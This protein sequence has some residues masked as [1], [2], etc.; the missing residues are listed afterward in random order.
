[1]EQRVRETTRRTVEVMPELSV[2]MSDLVDKAVTGM[3]RTEDVVVS[4]DGRRLAVATINND[5]IVILDF[6]VEFRPDDPTPR[7]VALTSAATIGCDS[8][9][10]PHGVAW[11]DDDTLLVGNRQ[12]EVL[13]LDISGVGALVDGQQHFAAEARVLLGGERRI[14]IDSPGSVVVRATDEELADIVVCNNYT[15]QV[16]RHVV[17]RVHDYACLDEDIIVEAGLNV[18]DGAA[19]SRA[20]DWL[21][22]SNHYTHEVFL[23]RYDLPFGFAREPDGVLQGVNYPHG[24]RFTADGRYMLVADAG[25]PYV[26]VY[27]AFHGDW[28]GQRTPLRSARVMDDETFHAGR[29]NPQE[30]GPKGLEIIDAAGVVVLTSEAQS[31]AFFDLADLTG[32]H[33]DDRAPAHNVATSA[34]AARRLSARNAEARADVQR[35][36]MHCDWQAAVVQERED[37]IADLDAQRYQLDE[38]R[39]QLGEQLAASQAEVERLS[40]LVGEATRRSIVEQD[41]I[42]E[43]E[44]AIAALHA[45]RSWR[46]TGPMRAVADRVKRGI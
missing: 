18:P 3:G 24:L 10:R 9:A 13:V 28:S 35:L 8:M 38:Q 14:Q 36:Q 2:S 42:A 20:G 7:G 45:S 25:L 43:L 34:A 19:F 23:Y 11:L 44:Q 27:H 6:A 17:D 1:M 40:G 32:A 16:T 22:I 4:P 41:R 5:E 21:A 33:V 39:R 29:S 26:H 12:S 30:G 37:T 46:F 31:L 15:H